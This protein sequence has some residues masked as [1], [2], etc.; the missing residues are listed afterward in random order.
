[1]LGTIWWLASTP[2]WTTSWTVCDL[3]S[4]TNS[5]Y[6]WTMGSLMTAPV[7]DPPPLRPG[8]RPRP[9]PRAPHRPLGRVLFVRSYLDPLPP[10]AVQG[11]NPCPSFRMPTRVRIACSATPLR[12]P[13]WLRLPPTRAPWYPRLVYEREHIVP[14]LCSTRASRERVR[15]W[16]CST[17]RPFLSS[18]PWPFHA[19]G[20]DSDRP[21]LLPSQPPPRIWHSTIPHFERSGTRERVRRGRGRG[22]GGTV[23]RRQPCR[24]QLVEEHTLHTL[25]CLPPLQHT[26]HLLTGRLK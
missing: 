9:F 22:R 20:R 19:S 26:F 23:R 18:S 11:P 5:V 1:M 25:E 21:V 14:R 16:T 2:G 6:V 15:S 12:V 4:S 3:T 10:T 24:W 17:S 7:C 13:C 8:G